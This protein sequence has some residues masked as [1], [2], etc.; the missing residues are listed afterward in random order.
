MR[1]AISN[2]VTGAKFIAQW[3]ETIQKN[4]ASP[5]SQTSKGNNGNKVKL[6]EN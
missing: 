1:R 4:G 2:T 5:K 6:W 3:R